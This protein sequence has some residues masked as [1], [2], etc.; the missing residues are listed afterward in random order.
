MDEKNNPICFNVSKDVLFW[1]LML[2]RLG[3][4]FSVMS[5]AKVLNFNFKSFVVK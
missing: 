5:Q 1:R 4:N 2:L 3:L